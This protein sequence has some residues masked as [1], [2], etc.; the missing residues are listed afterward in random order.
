M[1][2][3]R[4]QPAAESSRGPLG[5]QACRGPLALAPGPG[6]GPPADRGPDGTPPA[7]PGRGG[8]PPAA[9]GR[10]GGSPG[11]D[12]QQETSVARG[13]RAEC[14][15]AGL[16]PGEIARLIY[17]RCEPMFGTT[18]VRAHR[19]AFGI[20][21]ADVV[22]QV[23]ARYVAEG[24][25]PPRFSETLLSAYEGAQKRP[26]PEY[27]HYLCC[28]YQA[29]PDDLGYEGGCLC[30]HRHRCS[31]P[32]LA[33]VT[34]AAPVT[35]TRPG[36]EGD[37][38][39]APCPRP[40]GLLPPWVPA[41]VGAGAPDAPGGPLST[42]GDGP[43]QAGDPRI[44]GG[45]ARPPAGPAA[46]GG[47]AR[48]QAA[49]GRG[50]GP[51]GPAAGAGAALPGMVL[52]GAGFPAET[53][54]DAVRRTLLRLTADA[55]A[56]VD[57]RFFGAAERIRRRLDDALLGS[58]VS[59]TMLDHWEGAAAE[60]GRQYLTIPP[61]RLL[62]DVLL[63]LGDVRRMCEHRQPLEFGG[64]LC[65]LAARLAGLAGMIMIN[66]GDQRLARSFFA[67][68][69]AAADETGD[70]PL[71]AWVAVREALVPL[72]YGDAHQ[73]VAAARPAADL[74]G[75]LAGPA[76]VMAPIVEARALA[77][78]VQ[79]RGG[80]AAS[81][82]RVSAALDQ[83]HETFASL[84]AEQQAGTAF[85]YTERQLLF[86]QGDA[87][88]VLGD[89]RGA[90]DAFAQA[91]RLY[92]PAE[93]LDRSLVTL[94]RARCRLAEGEPEEALRLGRET[95]SRLPSQQRPSLVLRAA[96][97]LGDAVAAEHGDC[98]ALRD[99]R[100]AILTS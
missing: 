53:D 62:C 48:G 7:D 15:A 24:R 100:E 45:R 64:R 9:A 31:T 91:L 70:R 98:P 90:D 78:Q 80:G 58:T 99:Y 11:G 46:A 20:A 67:T 94:G 93:F 47:P 72:Y 40:A 69:R 39:G 29:E 54:D 83:A 10:A 65:T 52:P 13:I 12:A 41:T 18:P 71:R 76:G 38:A 79:R 8:G 51:A 25:T 21:L 5:G 44:V 73:A 81:W 34:A 68:A 96:G 82:R 28:V 14:L 59:V 84:P 16:A 36:P 55:G 60:Y 75:R 50:D 37:P 77:R 22:A 85:G 57:S 74:A 89:H 17:D 87:L 32:V 61:L 27:L 63:D 86:H 19:L 42:A 92:S 26:G 95:V 56:P 1:G 97:S 88:I 23:R 49:V 3:E 66:V 35:A 30:G 43:E 4:A 6:G 2:A 33:P